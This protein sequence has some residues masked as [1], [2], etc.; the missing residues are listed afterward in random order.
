MRCLRDAAVVRV[1]EHAHRELTGLP[2]EVALVYDRAGRPQARFEGSTSA[3]RVP[4]PRADVLV[5][6]HPVDERPWPS[7]ADV[8]PL[9][10]GKVKELWVLDRGAEYALR[11]WNEAPRPRTRLN[12]NTA[13]T[14]ESLA[15]VGL[16]W[17][18]WYR[19]RMWRCVRRV[20]P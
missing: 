17:E 20:L 5:H 3:V 6:N 19:G 18:L 1:L 9:L 16:G 10:A 13:P 14:P 8:N 4:L 15:E 11:V 12:P 2:H 7:G